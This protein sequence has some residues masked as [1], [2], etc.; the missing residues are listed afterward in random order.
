MPVI[1][2]IVAVAPGAGHCTVVAATPL[3][4]N[5][6]P[7]AAQIVEIVI[8][9]PALVQLALLQVLAGPGAAH[10]AGGKEGEGARRVRAG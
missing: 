4:L 1:T 3:T 7:A 5:V 2:S 6:A 8:T 9:S 10:V